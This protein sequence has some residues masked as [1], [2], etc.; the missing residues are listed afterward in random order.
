MSLAAPPTNAQNAVSIPS[1][2]ET[3]SQLESARILA[4]GDATLYGQIVGGVIPVINAQAPLEIRRW[5]ADFL[6]ETF[7]SPVI[8]SDQKE[9]LAVRDLGGNSGTVLQRLR[10]FLEIPG[11]DAGVVKSVVQA[12]A[13][14]YPLMF[15]HT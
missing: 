9:Q 7:A 6:A 1:A 3:I 12:A 10:E 2:R 13:N 4:L 8:S 15:R 14:I 11:E 5:G